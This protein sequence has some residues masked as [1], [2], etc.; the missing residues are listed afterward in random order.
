MKRTDHQQY[1]EDQTS[2][3]YIT[4]YTSHLKRFIY[5]SVRVH[6]H[7]SEHM[8][9]GACGSQRKVLDHLELKLEGL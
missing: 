6:E 7:K 4:Y 2:S 1:R 9:S 8:Y 5:S 3:L